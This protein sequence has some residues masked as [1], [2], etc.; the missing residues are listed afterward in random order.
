MI[1]WHYTTQNNY[2]KIVESGLLKSEN[3]L[4]AERLKARPDWP[5]IEARMKAEPA[6]AEAILCDILPERHKGQFSPLRCKPILWFS[7][8]Q[9][10]ES[11]AAIP[12]TF[13]GG[14]AEEEANIMAQLT[15]L[16]MCER[17]NGL[18]RL[19]LREEE[20]L[21]HGELMIRAGVPLP[22]ALWARLQSY[23][24]HNVMGLVAESLPLSQIDVVEKFVSIAEDNAV[25]GWLPISW[26]RN[27]V[28]S[29][30]PE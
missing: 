16:E 19:G 28:N 14:T 27:R 24:E 21:K 2:D 11:Q 9:V 18:V 6:K 12:N 30:F 23:N 10:W 29:A 1:C 22:V 13:K 5:E 4:I 8:N 25:G 20:L 7:R 26:P 3:L 15:Q 17:G